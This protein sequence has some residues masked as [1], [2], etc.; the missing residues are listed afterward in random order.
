[1][2]SVEIDKVDF[3]SVTVIINVEIDNPNAMGL[4]LDVYDYSLDAWDLTV[5]EGWV[6]ESIFLNASGKFNLPIP[7]SLSYSDLADVGTSLIGADTV[8]LDIA[9][10]LQVDLISLSGAEVSLLLDIRNPNAFSMEIWNMYGSLLVGHQ[11]W[12]KVGLDSSLY[13]GGEEKKLRLSQR[14]SASRK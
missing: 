6:D 4:T 1:M 5:V 9:L 7:V 8:P 2:S 14:K 10:G 13:L 3:E 12:G 11:E